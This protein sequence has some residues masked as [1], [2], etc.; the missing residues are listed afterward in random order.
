[1]PKYV[2]P[3]VVMAVE[4]RNPTEP[5]LDCGQ[6]QAPRATVTVPMAMKN[7]GVK[8]AAPVTLICGPRGLILSA[9]TFTVARD[10][11][12]KNSHR[13]RSAILVTR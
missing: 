11:A 10:R 7:H 3:S 8:T 6:N 13:H 1:L 5:K 9:V 4:F 12:S 2:G